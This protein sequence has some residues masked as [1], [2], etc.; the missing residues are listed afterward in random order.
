MRHSKGIIASAIMASALF[1]VGSAQPAGAM[2]VRIAK[3]YGISYL[4]LTLMEK[5][6]L[7]V[8]RGKEQGVQI[9]PHWL[10][11]TGGAS[12]NE[13]L[14]SNN[15]D[16]ASGGVAPMLVITDRTRDNLGVRGLACMNSMPLYLNTTNPAVHSLKDFTDKDRIALPAV[17]VSIQA[18]ILD[19]A[20]AKEFGPKNFNK[21][22]SLTVSMSHPDGYSALLNGTAGITAHFTSAPFMYEELQ[23]P[24]VHRVL[25]SFK[26]LGGPHTFNCLWS[27]KKFVSAN[28][29]VVTAFQMALNDA[30]TFIRQHPAQAAKVYLSTQKKTTLS[31]ADVEKMIKDP[32][33]KWTIQP[34]KVLQFSSFMKQ[35]GLV[36]NAAASIGDLFF[37]ETPPITGN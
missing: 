7:L 37:A 26:V 9:T 28:P 29:K 14:I 25:D 32:E 3:E 10:S 35:I 30:E 34:Q 13:A 16:I 23:N 22:D 11:F 36:K 4:P 1:V 19:M 24:K 15:L 20:A 18:I 2:D 21:L 27:T 6:D 8:K 31:Q 33:N 17:K 12:M 5:Q